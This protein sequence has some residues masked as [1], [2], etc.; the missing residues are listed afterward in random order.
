M[1]TTTPGGESGQREPSRSPSQVGGSW[2]GSRFYLPEQNDDVSA[3]ILPQNCRRSATVGQEWTLQLLD[4]GPR[5]DSSH[6]GSD[7]S[8]ILVAKD[9]QRYQEFHYYLR[10]PSTDQDTQSPPIRSVIAITGTPD[11]LGRYQ[12]WFIS[13]SPT[14]WGKAVIIVIVDRLSKYCQE[15]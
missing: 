3:S 15:G 9:G 13:G 11:D 5:W 10:N 6:H 4:W 8:T 7:S 2:I 12:Y 14:V 1:I